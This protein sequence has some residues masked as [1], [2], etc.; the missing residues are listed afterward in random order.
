MIGPGNKWKRM[1]QEHGH[2]THTE[3]PEH[4]DKPY[5]SLLDAG[6]PKTPR[7]KENSAEMA[8]VLRVLVY[9]GVTV[10]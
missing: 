5:R 8:S 9:M 3:N 6:R 10:Y 2:A 4:N 1:A 7:A